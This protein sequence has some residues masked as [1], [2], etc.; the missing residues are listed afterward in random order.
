MST[1]DVYIL[2]T[3][4][5]SK[6]C[7]FAR[8]SS[9]GGNVA[10]FQPSYDFIAQLAG[11]GH[12]L[13]LSPVSFLE[14]HFLYHRWF[15]WDGKVKDRASFDEIF[16]RDATYELDD[17]QKSEIDSIF[18]CFLTEATRLG[19]EF[20]TIDQNDVFR[21]AAFLYS[22]TKPSVEA[23]DLAIYANAI[24]DSAKYVITVDGQLLRAINH[25]RQNHKGAI[26]GQIISSF[27]EAKYP[28]WRRRRDLPNGRKPQ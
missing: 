15:Y 17:S 24:L 23:Y 22:I 16:G 2:D 19:I 20:S 25:F 6:I 9:S 27:G 8:L 3:S 7:E 1:L 4:V 28:Y 10:R 21:L 14:L 5:L 11:A 13:M 26:R 18:S 12:R